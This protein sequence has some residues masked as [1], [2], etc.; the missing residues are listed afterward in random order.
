M[1]DSRVLVPG[2]EPLIEAFLRPHADSSMFFRN[3]LLKGGLLDE[4]Q[5]FGG[6]WTGLFLDGELVSVAGVFW[7]GILQVQAPRFPAETARRAAANSPRPLRGVVG[8][9]LQVRAAREALGLDAVPC[10][11]DSREDLFSLPL[12]DLRVPP[13]LGSGRV[14]ARVATQDDFDL[15]V[16]WGVDYDCEL[17]GV[18]PDARL[19]Q[20]NVDTANTFI[21]A[22]EQFVLEAGGVPV[23]T[24]TWNAHL[25]DSVQIGGVFTPIPL[26][27]RG[28]ARCV[29]AGCLQI[30]RDAGI[31]R[32]ILFTGVTN[33]PAQAAYRAIGFARVGDYAIALFDGEHAVRR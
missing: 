16:R 25:P 10:S 6:T 4:G 14:T 30:A 21:A 19:L 2:D 17:K 1:L 20:D 7:N 9:W 27:G 28:Y 15:L 18:R 12:A 13:A 22:G 26:R 33:R 23:S 32:S 8:P 5:R 31:E 11:M 3:N 29:V 24:C